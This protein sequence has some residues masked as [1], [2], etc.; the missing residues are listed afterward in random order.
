MPFAALNAG[1]VAI[2][3]PAPV[4]ITAI[5]RRPNVLLRREAFGG[6]EFKESGLVSL[7]PLGG[8]KG[9]KL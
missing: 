8:L 1:I 4:K 9:S 3:K 2:V 5:V 6:C 7:Q